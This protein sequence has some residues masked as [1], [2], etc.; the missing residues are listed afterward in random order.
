VGTIAI[1]LAKDLGAYVATTCSARNAELV[2]SLGADRVID[3]REERFDEILSDYDFVLDAL[4]GEERRRSL[5]I[6]KRGG[7][8]STMVAGFPEF[9]EKHGVALGAAMATASLV[10]VTLEAWTRYGV[11]VHHVLRD[12][13]GAQLA[14]LTRRIERGAIRPVIDRVLPLADI[15]EAHRLSE[16]GHARGKIVIAIRD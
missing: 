1:Q 12:S 5:R 3:Y 14:Q 6:L 13:D 4:G 10:S 7:V 15:A 2:R 8:C 11:Y 9:A 16:A